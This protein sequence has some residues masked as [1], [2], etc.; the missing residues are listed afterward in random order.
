MAG[1][2]TRPG[3]RRLT[4]ADLEDVPDDG[5]RYELVDGELIVSPAP[6]YRHQKVVGRLYRLL[7]DHCPPDLD[8][9]FAPFAVALS[10]D[11]EIQPDLLVA[12]R[13]D[14]LDAETHLPSAPLL[15]VEVLSPGSRS[16]DLVLKRERLERAGCPSYWVV[17]PEALR[18]TAWE[19]V[20]GAY[21]LVSDLGPDDTWRAEQPYPVALTP[22]RLL[23]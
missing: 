17:D 18:L 21:A 22:G 4:R 8:V 9:L 14:L 2:T 1:M 6:R 11:T 10:E 15:A 12:R 16:R 3:T 13:S 5:Y 19:L 20:D 23:D 7:D